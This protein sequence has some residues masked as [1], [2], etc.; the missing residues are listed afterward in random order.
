MV[1]IDTT[2]LRVYFVFTLQKGKDNDY[3]CIIL[4][5]T[6]IMEISVWLQDTDVLEQ[7][8]EVAGTK[9]SANQCNTQDSAKIMVCE[10]IALVIALWTSIPVQITVV[11]LLYSVS[12][13]LSFTIQKQVAFNLP[14]M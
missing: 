11:Y 2:E 10:Q 3:I 5:H 12:L 9:M 14:C 13:H 7:R 8:K 4:D 1:F 6:L